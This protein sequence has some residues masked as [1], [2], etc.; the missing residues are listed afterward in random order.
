M[1]CTGIV[2]ITIVKCTPARTKEIIKA[3]KEKIQKQIDG[4]ENEKKELE[5]KMQLY[6]ELLDC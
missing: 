2:F 6:Q 3:K 1:I 4:W 5:S